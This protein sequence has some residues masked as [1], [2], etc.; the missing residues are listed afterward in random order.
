MCEPTTALLVLTAASTAAGLY[1]QQQQA[2]AQ[3]AYNDQQAK[4]TME[5]YRAN[6]AQTNLM[7][8]QEQA[9]ASQKINENNRAAEAAK[10]KALVSAGESGI[11]GLSVDALL[12]D[13][14]GE[15]SRYNESVNQNY[16]NASMAIDNQRKNVQ[17]NAASQINQLKTP[18]SPDYLG[19]ALRIGQAYDDYKNPRVNRK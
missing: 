17:I 2:K 9:A 12:A 5:A 4:N 16:E 15:Q 7:Q 1:G 10:A 14:S 6:L 19:A 13:L 8:S 18:Q 3:N 11:S